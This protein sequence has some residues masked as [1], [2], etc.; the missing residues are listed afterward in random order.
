MANLACSNTARILVR[1]HIGRGGRFNNQ[2]HKT[3][4][5]TARGL[6]DCFGDAFIIS[7]DPD[8]NVLPDKDWQLVDGGGN[9]IL[10]GRNA[11]ESPVGVLDWDGE[12]DTDIVRYLS[13]CSDEEY[14]L[15]IDTFDNGEYV[16]EDVIDHACQATGQL[17]AKRIQFDGDGGV[18]VQTQ[19]KTA[20]FSK[21]DFT[22]RETAKDELK[23]MG[24]IEES[25]EC[26]SC[27]MEDK[28]WF[29]EDED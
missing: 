25:A 20:H 2:G 6:S 15:I 19:Y 8:G 11:I 26:I 10:Q 1:F 24:F 3:Y 22:D 7:E 14:R 16:D 23:F 27:A 28:C 12:Y 17:H 21:D 9:V 4:I 18:D 13:E 5:G 29:D